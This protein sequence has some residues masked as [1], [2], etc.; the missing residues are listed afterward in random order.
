M[1]CVRM[2]EPSGCVILYYIQVKPK[3]VASKCAQVN[4]YDPQGLMGNLRVDR[5]VCL[6]VSVILLCG[7]LQQQ[8]VVDN[9]CKSEIFC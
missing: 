6:T 8:S 1:S 2:V 9:E 4:R 5:N 7:L 3:N